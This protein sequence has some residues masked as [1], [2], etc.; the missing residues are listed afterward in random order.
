MIFQTT[1]H[2]NM[3]NDWQ[4]S[5]QSIT[6]KSFLYNSLSKR[7][8]PTCS[9]TF[10]NIWQLNPYLIKKQTNLF[11]SEK[12]SYKDVF[13]LDQVLSGSVMALDLRV[14]AYIITT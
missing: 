10:I 5:Y 4:F 8:N 6:V 11:I 12:L 3:I 2:D 1:K 7:S 9:Q 14:C 13:N